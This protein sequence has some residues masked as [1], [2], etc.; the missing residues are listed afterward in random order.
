MPRT[1]HKFRDFLERA[2]LRDIGVPALLAAAVLFVSAMSMLNANVS[3]LRESYGRVQRSNSVLLDLAEIN[4]LVMGID[5]TVRGYALT[6]NP[7][8]LVYEAD[9]RNR[10]GMAIDNLASLL[11]DEPGQSASMA[12]LRALVASHEEVFS[13]LSSLGPGHAKDVAAVIV[14]PE[15]RKIRYAVQNT[16]TA[17]H[18]GEMKQLSA[19]QQAVERQVSHTFNLALGIVAFAF[20]A[21][22]VGFALTLFGR[23][24]QS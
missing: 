13:Q 1:P 5:M 19:R 10:L 11:S 2:S 4:T 24:A 9:N 12:K 21:G 15:K 17:M 3:A 16:L 20:V 8:F 14:D 7:D 22:A 23:R 6:D 18:N